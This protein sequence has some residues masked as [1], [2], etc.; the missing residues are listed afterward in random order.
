MSFAAEAV[1]VIRGILTDAPSL[2]LLLGTGTIIVGLFCYTG[3]QCIMRW[4]ESKPWWP[5][6]APR[7]KALAMNFGYKEEEIT[8][9]A[10]LEGWSYVLVIVI[11]HTFVG[12]LLL[13]LAVFGATSGAV[14][15][16]LFYLGL[17][18]E[19]CYDVWD[20]LK[21][22]ALCFCPGTFRCMEPMP[23]KMYIIMVICHHTPILVMALP[24]L[25][26]Y[27]HAAE[28]HRISCAL[29]LAA[30]IAFSTGSYKFTLD[31]SI[32][33]DFMRYKMI[34]V[35]QLAVILYARMWLW[36]TEAYSM[37][38]RFREDGANGFWW[39]G[40]TGILLLS[41]FNLAMVADAIQA[42]IK[43]LPQ[44]RPLTEEG[45]KELEQSK[46]ATS[47]ALLPGSFAQ[48]K[49]PMKEDLSGSQVEL[50]MG[51]VS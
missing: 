21:G 7:Q 33:R 43:W 42:A 27:P 10:N 35:F 16:L 29:I 36:F 45:Q 51:Q 5:A 17:L 1:E 24:L 23:M 8:D 15:M 49:G 28:F 18:L 39:A 41:I 30:G 3:M 14:G 19:F 11:H 40:L 50:W 26:H 6:A 4:T 2:A 20:S 37:L 48:G 34:V 22:T 12:L 31:T 38:D 47:F 13:P 25:I 32:P 9:K 44:Q 46:S